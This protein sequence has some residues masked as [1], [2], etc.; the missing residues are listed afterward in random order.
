MIS[1][2]K[3]AD[4]FGLRFLAKLTIWQNR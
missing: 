4:L 3:T 2:S 1:L